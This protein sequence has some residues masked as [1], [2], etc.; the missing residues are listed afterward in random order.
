MGFASAEDAK[1]DKMTGQNAAHRADYVE[2]KRIHERNDEEAIGRLHTKR[3]LQGNLPVQIRSSAQKLGLAVKDAYTADIAAKL[4]T[5]QNNKGDNIMHQLF[6]D[7]KAWL[8][9]F[10]TFKNTNPFVIKNAISARNKYGKI[11]PYQKL[12]RYCEANNSTMVLRINKELRDIFG[13]SSPINF[14]NKSRF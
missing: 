1:I 12:E 7:E 11:T 3:D 14:D 8:L 9:L 13:E 2:L 6:A 4:F 10:D 5:N